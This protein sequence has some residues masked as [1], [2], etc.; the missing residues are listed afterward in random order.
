[1]EKFGID[2]L[3]ALHIMVGCDALPPG[4]PGCGPKRGKEVM[5]YMASNNPDKARVGM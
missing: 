4:V 3:M 5:E 1:M 2:G